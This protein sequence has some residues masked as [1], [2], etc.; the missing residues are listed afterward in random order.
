MCQFHS[1]EV[2]SEFLNLS[3]LKSQFDSGPSVSQAIENKSKTVRRT[4]R[5][6]A[7][8]YGP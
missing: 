1:V 3:R 8:S 4:L 7:G 2:L 6:K 5:P